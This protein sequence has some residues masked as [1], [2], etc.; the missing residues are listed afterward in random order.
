MS[1]EPLSSR[2]RVMFGLVGAGVI[3]GAATVVAL[4][5]TP[6]TA[7]STYYRAAFSRAGQGLDPGKSDV[8]IRGITVGTVDR[9]ALGRDGRVDVRLRLDRGVRVPTTTAARIEPLSVFGPKDLVLDLGRNELSGPFLPA[10]G[11]IAQTRDPQELSETAWPT[12]RLTRAINPDELATVLRTFAAG[13]NGQGPALRRTID[14]GSKVIDATHAKRAVISRLIS[15]VSGISGTLGSRGDTW[16]RFTGD[17]NQVGPVI[18]ERPDKVQ[19]LLAE[20][21]DLADTVGGT[22]RRRGRDL[23]ELIDDAGDVASVLAQERRHIPTLLDTLNGFFNLLSQ[24]I[25]VPGPNGTLLAQAVDTL[26]LDICQ[27]L[28]DICP[29]RPTRT[30]FDQK[31]KSGPTMVVRP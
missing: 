21:G 26:P 25:R 12:Y 29:T 16:M 31:V 1:D 8:K 18:H 11:R 20:G 3:V 24:I 15:D 2:S 7:G 30:A 27:T 5:A 17:F 13:L 6:D 19:Q 22:L 23:G 4:G 9:V 28:V 10:G 14:N